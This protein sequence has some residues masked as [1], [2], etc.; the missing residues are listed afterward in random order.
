MER[1][2]RL[3]DSVYL[4]SC[5]SKSNIQIPIIEGGGFFFVD[6]DLEKDYIKLDL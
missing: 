6:L 4:F 2:V 3:Q 1:S 5:F